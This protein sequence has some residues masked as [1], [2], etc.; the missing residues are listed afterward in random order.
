VVLQYNAP[1]GLGLGVVSLL[2]QR[3]RG[4]ATIFANRRSLALASGSSYRQREAENNCQSSKL[5]H[6]HLNWY[7]RL[8]Q[9]SCATALTIWAVRRKKEGAA[10]IA[11]RARRWRH[12][13]RK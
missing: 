8:P 7:S 2:L 9:T 4:L 5:L 11:C 12:R 10:E 6:K 3:K 13:V 1:C